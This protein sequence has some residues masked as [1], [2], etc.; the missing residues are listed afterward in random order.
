MSG[1]D[2]ALP[3]L[4]NAT[5]SRAREPTEGGREWG[6]RW[7]IGIE[8]EFHTSHF[9]KYMVLGRNENK[10][11]DVPSIFDKDINLNVMLLSRS[12]C[13]WEGNEVSGRTQTRSFSVSC[14]ETHGTIETSHHFSQ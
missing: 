11:R 7:V 3:E 10:C 5:P 12:L 13:N 2:A 14:N 6:P 9:H 4:R 8:R 1:S